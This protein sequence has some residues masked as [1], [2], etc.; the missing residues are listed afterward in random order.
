MMGNCTFQVFQ[1][2]FSRLTLMEKDQ[3]QS[4]THWDYVYFARLQLYNQ[5]A[6][7]FN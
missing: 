2:H 6:N 7:P 5:P 1:V 3:I 4:Y